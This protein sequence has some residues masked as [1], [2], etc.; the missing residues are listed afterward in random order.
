MLKEGQTQA[1]FPT[2]F[3]SAS[4]SKSE[5]ILSAGGDEQS[6]NAFENMK[7]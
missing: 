7:K 1:V 4:L 6:L 5:I 3:Y 2:M